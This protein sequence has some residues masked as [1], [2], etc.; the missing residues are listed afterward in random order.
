M[1][2][3]LDPDQIFPKRLGLMNGNTLVLE[4]YHLG[5]DKFKKHLIPY[6]ITKEAKTIIEDIFKN[7]KHALYLKKVN[8]KHVRSVL[9]GN[10]I[11]IKKQKEHRN[12]EEFQ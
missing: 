3:Y 1:P 10:V 6:E 2:Q 11:G 4:Y 9:E 5:K 12:F 7:T 8:P